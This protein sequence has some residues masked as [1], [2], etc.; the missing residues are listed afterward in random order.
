MIRRRMPKRRPNDTHRPVDSQKR[1]VYAAEGEAFAGYSQPNIGPAN[2]PDLRSVMACDIWVN[3]QLRRKRL[4]DALHKLGVTIPSRIHINPTGASAGGG[5]TKINAGKWA[6]TEQV[7]LHELAH[8][9]NDYAGGW[10]DTSGHGREYARIYLTLVKYVLGTFWERRLRQAFRKHKVKY[11]PKRELTVDQ[12]AALSARLAAV[13]H[14]AVAAL[15][16]NLNDE[17]YVEYVARKHDGAIPL[18]D[19]RAFGIV[20]KQ[21]KEKETKL[22]RNYD[23]ARTLSEG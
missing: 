6:R 16:R 18:E 5:G 17:Q 8:I 1:K 23:I 4:R 13:R 22:S 2:R 14:K 12:R 11:L 3:R 19:D 9:L 7:L 15:P 10:R 21:Q 20:I